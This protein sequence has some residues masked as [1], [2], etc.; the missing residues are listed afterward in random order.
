MN[1]LRKL[2]YL[3]R[4]RDTLTKQVRAID[5]EINKL[6]PG[7]IRQLQDMPDQSYEDKDENVFVMLYDDIKTKFT[8][9][10]ENKRVYNAV[11]KTDL[12]G[13]V[14]PTIHAGTL[15]AYIKQRARDAQ[16]DIFNIKDVLNAQDKALAKYLDIS[17]EPRLVYRIPKYN[18]KDNIEKLYDQQN[19]LCNGCHEY[20]KLRNFTVDHITPRSKNGSDHISNLQLLCAK[21]NSVKGAGTQEEFIERLKKEGVLS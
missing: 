5:D 2:A 14:K 17:F 4:E 18:S 9:D 10:L 11:M 16:V 20:F 15:K 3:Q 13:K 19:G 21:C 12:A 6:A 8:G 7:A 1:V